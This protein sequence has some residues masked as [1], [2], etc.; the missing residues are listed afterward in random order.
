MSAVL[1][2]EGLT[3]ELP[4][5]RAAVDDV[6]IAVG[7]GEILGLVGESGSGKTTLAL[8]LLGYARPGCRIVAGSVEVAGMRLTGLDEDRGT[9]SS[10]PCR[11]VRPAGP[12]VGTESVACE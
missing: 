12:G 5:G 6:S 1:H 7:P 10:W 11:L 3:V 4:G 9:E 2:A 8:A